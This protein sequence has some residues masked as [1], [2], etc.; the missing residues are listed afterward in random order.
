[1][2]H[3]HCQH[4]FRRYVIAGVMS[5]LLMSTACGTPEPAAYDDCNLFVVSCLVSVSDEGDGFYRVKAAGNASNTVTELEEF[6]VLKAAEFT[7]EQDK[8][9]F[10]IVDSVRKDT[11]GSLWDSGEVQS[12]VVYLLI[13]LGAPVNATSNEVVLNQW[14]LAQAVYDRFAPI[15]KSQ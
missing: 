2:R 5:A 14:L 3:L 4:L 12:M 13:K 11:F 6:A 8:T 9:H 1:M 10:M 7:L 15:Y